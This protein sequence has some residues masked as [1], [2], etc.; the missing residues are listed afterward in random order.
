MFVHGFAASGAYFLEAPEREELAGRGIVIPD[1]PG[2]G[3]TAA[4]EGFAFTMAEQ[5][6]VVADT[7]DALGLAELTLVGHSMG[8]TIAV[9]AVEALGQR[10]RELVLVE[11]ILQ[12][13]PLAWTT[14]IAAMAPAA[15]E[16]ELERLRR[17]PLMFARG[18]MVRRRPHAIERVAPAI[19]QTTAVATHLSAMSLRETAADPTLYGRFRALGVPALYLFGDRN[20]DVAFY[21]RLRADQ[22]PIVVVHH[23]GHLMMLDNP[24][25]FY[26][27]VAAGASKAGGA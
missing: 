20:L 4:P 26:A 1:L 25:A 7:A 16:D 17:R 18:S 13:E 3:R 12:H 23:A 22:A 6:R 19:T 11:A 10:L 24:A 5:A 15:W 14:A 27:T 21:E 2:F 8:G 9:L